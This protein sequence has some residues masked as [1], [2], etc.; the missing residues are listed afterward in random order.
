M[1]L[2]WYGALVVWCSGGMVLWWL[3]REHIKNIKSK[4]Y[5]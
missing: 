4:E 5:K 2:W 3:W 1:V